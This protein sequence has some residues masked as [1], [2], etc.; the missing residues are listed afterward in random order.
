[1]VYWA[2]S[3]AGRNI[4]GAALRLARGSGVA[5]GPPQTVPAPFGEKI[6]G[7]LLFGENFPASALFGELLSGEYTFR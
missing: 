5:V 7:E 2:R 6:F 3:N 4:R 1:M